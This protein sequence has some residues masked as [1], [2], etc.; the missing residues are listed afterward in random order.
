MKNESHLVMFR[1]L[2]WRE[3]VLGWRRKSEVMS[4]LTFFVIIGCLFPLGLDPD[5]SLLRNVA[6]GVVWVSAL[7]ASMLGSVRLFTSDYADGTLDQ[8]LTTP[9][10]VILI[11]AGKVLS[12]F[13][14]TGIPLVL[15]S[16]FL[17]LQLGL[18]WNEMRTLAVSLLIGIPVLNLIA[19]FGSAL[20]LGIRGGGLA[21]AVIVIPLCVPVLVFGAGGNVL[22]VGA[23]LALTLVFAP[24]AAASALKI[25]VES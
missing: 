18:P 5:A 24:W 4:V 3:V 13:L 15:A 1:W 23:V 11:V 8:M 9:Q 19:A 14:L 2:L 17:A 6:P 7:L 25:S 12:Q 16:P 21:V 20:M 10:P 22:L